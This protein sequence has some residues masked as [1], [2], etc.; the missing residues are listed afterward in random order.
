VLK[1]VIFQK[2]HATGGN[3]MQLIPFDCAFNAFESHLFYNHCN[4]EGH[5]TIIFITMGTHHSDPLGKALFTLAHFWALRFISNHFP[6]Y[7]FPSITNNTHVIGFSSIV[8]SAYE[9]F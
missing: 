6:S 5:V 2:L 8:S 7:L 1:G 9:H 3:I 4:Y